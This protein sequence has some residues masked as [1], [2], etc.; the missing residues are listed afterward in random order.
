MKSSIYSSI[1][2]SSAVSTMDQKEINA[3]VAID[4]GTCNTRMAFANKPST[5]S[6]STPDSPRIVVMNEWECA[7][8]AVAAPTSIIISRH[9][10]RETDPCIPVYT[11]TAYGYEAEEMFLDPDLNKKDKPLLFKNFKMA[12][13]EKEVRNLYCSYTYSRLQRRFVNIKSIILTTKLWSNT[14]T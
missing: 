1:Y 9:R 12:L 6:G 14:R 10:Q 2:S 4:F 3:V 5:N 8:D 7:V 13:H 11:V